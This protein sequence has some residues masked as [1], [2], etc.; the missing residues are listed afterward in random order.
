[1]A[2]SENEWAD[3]AAVAHDPRPRAAPHSTPVH[4]GHVNPEGLTLLRPILGRAGR[5]L[6]GRSAGAPAG[7]GRRPL[8][9]PA[10]HRARR[11]PRGALAGMP[12]TSALLGV[13]HD[14][15][16]RLTARRPE[17]SGSAVVQGAGT[18]RPRW[19]RRP[20]ARAKRAKHRVRRGPHAVLLRARAQLDPVRAGRAGAGRRGRHRP[21]RGRIGASCSATTTS[22]PLTRSQDR[23]EQAAPVRRDVQHDAQAR[24]RGPRGSWRTSCCSAST[25]PAEA[26]TPM[27]RLGRWSTH[28][29]LRALERYAKEDRYGQTCCRP[30]KRL[31]SRDRRHHPVAL[32]P[33]EGPL[34]AR[35]VHQGPG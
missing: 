31:E 20:Q 34:P 19:P 35:R 9:R 7:S 21:R 27:T 13:L 32:E 30:P 10:A 14:H 1:M 11:T 23:R 18:A 8:P 6:A 29:N 22:R 3:A 16:G 28:Q 26:A 33:G 15:V 5:R 24:R 25:P 17:R 2:S 12:G 4:S